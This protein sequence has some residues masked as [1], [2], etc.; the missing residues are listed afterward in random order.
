MFEPVKNKR[1]EVFDKWNQFS[2]RMNDDDFDMLSRTVKL[3]GVSRQEI[4]RQGILYAL[5]NLRTDK[6]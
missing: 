1:A 4:S 6:L 2:V 5:K 3:T